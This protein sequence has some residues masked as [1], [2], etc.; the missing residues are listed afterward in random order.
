MKKISNKT[1]YIENKITFNEKKSN[2]IYKEAEEKSES[3]KNNAGQ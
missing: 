3:Q 1:L 2:F